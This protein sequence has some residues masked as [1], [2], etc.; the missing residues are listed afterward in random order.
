[1]LVVVAVRMGEVRG[2]AWEASRASERATDAM[3]T[4]CGQGRR[5]TEHAGL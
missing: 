2:A 4:G 5:R 1:M 3:S